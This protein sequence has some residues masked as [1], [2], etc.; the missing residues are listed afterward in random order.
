MD[1]PQGLDPTPL[2]VGK[3]AIVIAG[4]EGIVH[5]VKPRLRRVRGHRRDAHQGHD[6]PDQGLA[7]RTHRNHLSVTTFT[8]MGCALTGGTIASPPTRADSALRR[9]NGPE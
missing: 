4:V 9:I 7:R 3:H 8:A 6:E 2:P 5:A 1:N